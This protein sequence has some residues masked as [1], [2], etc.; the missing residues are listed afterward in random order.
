MPTVRTLVRETIRRSSNHGSGTPA[1]PHLSQEVLRSGSGGGAHEPQR[2]QRA[3]GTEAGAQERTGRHVEREVHAQVEPREATAAAIPSAQG[4][5]RGLMIAT[6]VA[7]ANAVALWPDGNEGLSGRG[8]SEPSEGSSSGG[9]A[10]SNAPLRRSEASEAA[11]TASAAAPKASGR[12][13][14]R[15]S[16][17]RPSPTSSGPLTHQADRITKSAVSQGCSKAGAASITARSR[18]SRRAIARETRK[19]ASRRRYS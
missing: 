9:R 7:A 8:A 4:R 19:L 2:E 11:A 17:H 12:R 5:S 1:L 3:E 13:L 15:R 6:A 14:Q 10:R 18:S 16:E